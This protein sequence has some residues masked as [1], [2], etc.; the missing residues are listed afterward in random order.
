MNSICLNECAIKGFDRSIIAEIM[1][2]EHEARIKSS[3]VFSKAKVS[4]TKFRPIE[5]INRVALNS[6]FF[7]AVLPTIYSGPL[8]MWGRR[9][10]NC[11]KP[12][13]ARSPAKDI[14]NRL[15]TTIHASATTAASNGY[16][17]NLVNSGLLDERWGGGFIQPIANKQDIMVK[18]SV[19][20]VC[21]N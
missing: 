9:K 1:V 16:N 21:G 14:Q 2:N 10:E 7:I 3:S 18:V 8:I 6:G 13:L 20:T 17:D 11:I 4:F 12:E 5:Q 15:I 19:T